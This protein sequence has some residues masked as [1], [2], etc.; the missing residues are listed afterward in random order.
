MPNPDIN[1]VY[2]LYSLPKKQL[3]KEFAKAK[4]I[5]EYT[6]EQDNEYSKKLT[7]ES[8]LSMQFNS[9]FSLQSTY[10][11]DIFLILLL[12]IDFVR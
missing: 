12:L 1:L 11:T 9:T 3:I 5:I 4:Q 6:K 7:S 10:L 8:W 2:H